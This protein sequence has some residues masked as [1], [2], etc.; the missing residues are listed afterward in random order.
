MSIHDKNLRKFNLL[1]STW[2]KFRA[3]LQNTGQSSSGEIPK[4]ISNAIK[5][6]IG[7][8]IHEPVIGPNQKIYVINEN[9]KLYILDLNGMIIEEIEIPKHPSC[10]IFLSDDTFYLTAIGK[11]QHYN[12]M[13][14]IIWERFIDG[15][16]TNIT[17]NSKGIIYFAAHSF[18]WAGL[19]AYTANGDRVFD[20][21]LKKPFN[22]RA[23]GLGASFSA[24]TLTYD[25]SIIIAFRFFSTYT[26]DPEEGP[27]PEHQYVCYC[28]DP[29]GTKLWTF[30]SSQLSLWRPFF[31]IITDE[32][33]V[34]ATFCNQLLSFN[35]GGQTSNWTLN[36]FDEIKDTDYKILEEQI[37]SN[38]IS[39]FNFTGYPTYNAESKEFY[40][41]LAG[42]SRVLSSEPSSHPPPVEVGS[43][44]II[45]SDFQ[46]KNKMKYRTPL[47]LTTDL[48]IDQVGNLCGG[49]VN[50]ILILTPTCD[51]IFSYDLSSRIKYCIIGPKKTII[52]S[53]DSKNLYILK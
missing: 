14:E 26:W 33:M 9:N 32:N 29:D 50:G 41:R 36:Y 1:D 38:K 34:L 17:I 15:I 27:E 42:F 2:P 10:P 44:Y 5:I 43:I 25:E 47:N 11:V 28:I 35:E 6:S 13:G 7:K 23:H 52:C 51:L 53:D 8:I 49:G 46:L 24:P 18:D 19:Y 4:T 48:A 21:P 31:P 20:I 45:H 22:I 3:N 16:P 40:C 39:F 30:K 37:E 12:S